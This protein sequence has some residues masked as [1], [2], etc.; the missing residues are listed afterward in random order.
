MSE[1]ESKAAAPRLSFEDTLHFYDNSLFDAAEQKRVKELPEMRQFFEQIRPFAERYRLSPLIRHVQADYYE[2]ESLLCGYHGSQGHQGGAAPSVPLPT[3]QWHTKQ[4]IVSFG[5]FTDKPEHMA[6]IQAHSPS[7]YNRPG[8]RKGQQVWPCNERRQWRAREVKVKHGVL[9]KP[10]TLKLLQTLNNQLTIED[11]IRLPPE[12]Q[13]V[14]RHVA[15][16]EDED[17]IE[18]L[19]VRHGFDSRF[20]DI[21]PCPVP[22]GLMCMTTVEVKQTQQE[23]FGSVFEFD[24]ILS[25]LPTN[26]GV[27]TRLLESLDKAA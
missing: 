13:K 18:D 25:D 10:L 12:A 21:L 14:L 15:E 4:L 19:C 17:E 20:V 5:I 8:G 2:K 1:L 26:L 7:F 22:D 27:L 6:L 24:F 9:L 23:H 16:D 11:L 3:P